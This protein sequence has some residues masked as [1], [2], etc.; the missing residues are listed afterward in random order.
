MD[1]V[2]GGCSI[3]GPQ[4]L[5]LLL[6]SLQLAPPGSRQQLYKRG[7]SKHFTGHLA[8][9]SVHANLRDTETVADVPPNLASATHE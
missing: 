7:C 9:Y 6:S 3:E 4:K 8:P 2:K 5:F 1:L